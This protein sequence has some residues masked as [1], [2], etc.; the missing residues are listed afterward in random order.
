MNNSLTKLTKCDIIYN[1]SYYLKQLFLFRGV[2]AFLLY[3]ISKSL[4]V[5]IVA[6]FIYYFKLK[7]EKVK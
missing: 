1:I 7:G 6:F 4:S 3:F 5:R 2:T